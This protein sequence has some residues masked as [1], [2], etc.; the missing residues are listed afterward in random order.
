MSNGAA[1][2][3]SGVA[4]NDVC[5]TVAEDRARRLAPEYA[6]LAEVAKGHWAGVKYDANRPFAETAKL[7]RKEL[8]AA[9]KADGPLNGVRCRVRSRCASLCEAID[10]TVAGA[11][12]PAVQQAV[13]AVARQYCYDWSDRSADYSDVAFYLSVNFEPA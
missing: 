11:W 9:S 7:I 6:R 13:E 1:M 12:S 4:A 8:A 10:I 3:L 2:I 5:A